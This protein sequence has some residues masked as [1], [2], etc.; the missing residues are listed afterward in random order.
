MLAPDTIVSGGIIEDVVANSPL[1]PKV[2]IA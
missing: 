1:S 2:A